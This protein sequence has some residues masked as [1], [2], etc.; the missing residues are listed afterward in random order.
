MPVQID[1][2]KKKQT[3][4]FSGELT[5]T[6]VRSLA[7]SLRD[8]TGV[9]PSLELVLENVTTADLAFWQLLL[10]VATTYAGQGVPVTLRGVRSEPSL[11]EPLRLTGLQHYFEEWYVDER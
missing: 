10:R 11:E 4:V 9:P 6:Q 2:G 8:H 3:V 7:D 1:T 5:V